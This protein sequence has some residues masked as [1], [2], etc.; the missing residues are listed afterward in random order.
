VTGFVTAFFYIFAAW[1]SG[2]TRRPQNI[3][4]T[5]EA[6]HGRNRKKQATTAWINP[7]SNACCG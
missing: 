1:A 5:P 6:R 7:N 2:Q 4:K 3:L